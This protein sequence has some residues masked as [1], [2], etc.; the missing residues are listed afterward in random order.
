MRGYIGKSGPEYVPSLPMGTNISCPN[1]ANADYW[2]NTMMGTVPGSSFSVSSPGPA[3]QAEMMGR[4]GGGEFPCLLAH[5]AGSSP[6]CWPITHFP[7]RVHSYS[8]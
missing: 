4:C 8:S 3:S 5:Y 1:T 2:V 6:A 7:R